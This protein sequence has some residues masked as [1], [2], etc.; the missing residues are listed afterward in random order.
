VIFYDISAYK[1]LHNELL[2]KNRLLEALNSQQNRYLSL[3]EEMKLMVDCENKKMSLYSHRISDK[4]LQL[5]EKIEAYLNTVKVPGYH[6]QLAGL[7]RHM[8]EFFNETDSVEKKA[9]DFERMQFEKLM[10]SFDE[11]ERLIAEEGKPSISICDSWLDATNRSILK[12]VA[13]GKSNKEIAQAINFE[14]GSVKNRIRDMIKNVVPQ[15][16]GDKRCLLVSYAYE[17]GLVDE[18]V[19]TDEDIFIK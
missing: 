1:H 5:F 3:I 13:K 14:E 7:F 6:V 18:F 11:V 10:E 8:Q 2:E 17:K 16:Q 15:G 19:F 9:P 12:L 4:L